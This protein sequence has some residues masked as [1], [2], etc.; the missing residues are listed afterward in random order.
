M[1]GACFGRHFL[2]D[3]V[4]V[5]GAWLGPLL[6]GLFPS[7]QYLAWDLGPAS[8]GHLNGQILDG[9]GLGFLH[10]GHFGGCYRDIFLRR[11]SLGING[12]RRRCKMACSVFFI[13]SR[14]ALARCER[15][16][17]CATP[18]FLVGYGR[19]WKTSKLV[20]HWLAYLISWLLV[21]VSEW[22]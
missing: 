14:R 3:H 6:S 8:G 12:S 9:W 21:G 7:W 1:R 5:G 18:M 2:V 15:I 13:M 19:A 10:Y 22:S 4:L 17:L 11:T 20:A 16:E